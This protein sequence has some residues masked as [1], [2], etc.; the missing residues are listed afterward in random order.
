MNRVR[1]RE[2]Y[3]RK[4]CPHKQSVLPATCTLDPGAGGFRGLNLI[5]SSQPS[6]PPTHPGWGKG[7]RLF[8]HPKKVIVYACDHGGGGHRENV[9]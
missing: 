7:F 8:R 1:G 5:Q 3:N 4:G 2:G 6:H 9:D